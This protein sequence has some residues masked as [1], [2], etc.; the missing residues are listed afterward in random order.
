MERINLKTV[1]LSLSAI[2]F[3]ILIAAA[4]DC[5]ECF[6][7]TAMAVK[8]MLVGL[9]FIGAAFLFTRKWAKIDSLIYK[10]E[11]QP[12][13]PARHCTPETPAQVYGKITAKGPLLLS[14]FTATECVFYHYIKEHYES[15]GDSSH[16]VVDENKMNYID[17]DVE[18]RSG[19]IGICLRNVD[20]V[21]GEKIKPPKSDATLVDYE[22]SEVDAVK[23]SYQKKFEEEKKGLVF[24]G[25]VKCRASEYILTEGQA[26]FVNG[27][28]CK[29][30][31]KKFLAESSE[32]PL[33]LSRKTKES[34]LEDFAKGDNF[35]YDSNII[36]LIGSTIV[37]W[38]ANL[39]LKIPIQYLAVVAAIILGRIAYNIFNRMVA[40]HNRCENAKSQI[41]IE[42]KKRNDLLPALAEVTKG[43]A[44]HE[45][46][47]QEMV[48]LAR[49]DVGKELT[50]EKVGEYL[51]KEKIVRGIFLLSE[52]Y[53]A[54]KAS[55]IFADLQ[56]R[57]AMLEENIAY[58]RGFYNK[59]VLKFNTLTGQFPFLIIA[60][61]F[62]FKE[63]EY[64]KFEAH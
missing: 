15:S 17:F 27:W 51:E 30:G 31:G 44:K 64:Y 42:L 55:E 49:M 19:G 18:D 41:M 50:K 21:L 10:I 60:V 9:I 47:L 14:P 52:K 46:N 16:W 28:V 56:G 38:L 33:I 5:D 7:P 36:L 13:L 59:T 26:V 45:M 8:I 2:S 20:S 37:F 48:A 57:T 34:Y 22:N 23:A 39:Y 12:I 40:L 53:P 24:T 62:R 29:E 3:V 35:F 63:K 61:I 1:M 11:R 32:M 54:L 4:E 43:Y 25:K 58:F 6:S